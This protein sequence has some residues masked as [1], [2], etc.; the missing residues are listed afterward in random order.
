MDVIG[1]IAAAIIVIGVALLVF[2]FRFRQ[3]DVLVLS[4]S[5]GHIGVRK[6]LIYPRHFSLPLKRTTWPIQLTTEASAAGNLGMRVKLVGS[7]APSADH[8]QSLI[9][10]GGW[11]TEAVA[12]VADGLEQAGFVGNFRAHPE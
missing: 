7:I 6:G 9:R 5:K 3:P 10:A 2:E 11:N 12:R 1:V 4:E 8:V